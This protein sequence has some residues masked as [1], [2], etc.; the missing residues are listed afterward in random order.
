MGTQNI[1]SSQGCVDRTACNKSGELTGQSS[2]RFHLC[3]VVIVSTR[4]R[5]SDK[6]RKSRS[7]FGIFDPRKIRGGR[8]LKISRS[9]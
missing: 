5:F 2:F 4:G 7:N 3:C 6:G 9:V 1:R 8:G